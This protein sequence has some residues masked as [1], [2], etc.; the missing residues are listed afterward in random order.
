MSDSLR[1]YGLEP[2]R[3]LCPGDSPG[4]YTGVGGHALLQGIFPIWGLNP[5]LLCLLHWQV[6]S[7][8]LV[9]PGK[10]TVNVVCPNHS[11]TIH[12]TPVCGKTVFYHSG[13]WCQKSWGLLPYRMEMEI[14]SSVL[15]WE[16][17]RTQDPGRLQSMRLQ[18]V[19]HD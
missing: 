4:K 11:Q 19:K 10:S 15:A 14:H 13:P 2:A 18:R 5:C 16:I 3:L 17:P 9:L 8:P 6:G 1:P 12:A 7:L